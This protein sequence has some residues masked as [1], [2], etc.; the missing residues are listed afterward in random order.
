MKALTG[1]IERHRAALVRCAPFALYIALMAA[2]PLLA[3][4][5]PEIDRRWFYA[6]KVVCVAALLGLFLRAYGELRSGPRLKAGEWLVS[7]AVG[8]AVFLVWIQLD[9]P[10]LSVGESAGFD[11]RDAAGEIVWTWVLIRLC[12]AVLVVP[13]M[14]ELF[15]RSFLMRWIDRQDF[16]ALP[17]AAVSLRALFLSALVFGLAHNLWFAGLLAGLAYGWLYLRSG[18]LWSPILSH[19]L[20][21][22][23]LGLWVL[24]TGSW[25][26]W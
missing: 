3:A 9:L 12:G 10:W 7:L 17:P 22:L 25:Q 6:V 5:L 19:A 26:F 1:P 8:G 2:T 11:P 15:W 23:L 13:L 18:N 14:E 16:L 24:H 20:T 4:A 21:N